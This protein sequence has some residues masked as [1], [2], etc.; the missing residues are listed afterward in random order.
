[1]PKVK[2]NGIKELED[3]Q[4]GASRTLVLDALKK[5]ATSSQLSPKNGEQPVS[6]SKE[7]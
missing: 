1:M 4:P 2:D 6:T 5:V 7:T 3:Y